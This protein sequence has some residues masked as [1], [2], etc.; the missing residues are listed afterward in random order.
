MVR[1]APSASFTASSR[2]R[3]A[4]RDS[5]RLPALTQALTSSSTVEPSTT[6]LISSTWD[7]ADGSSREY[8][9]ADICRGSSGFV[10]V[11]RLV[12]G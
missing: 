3:E 12:S 7:L 4:L 6:V 10:R 2:R 1:L 9:A 5:S 11:P 8:D